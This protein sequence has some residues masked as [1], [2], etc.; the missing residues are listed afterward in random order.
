MLRLSLII[1]FLLIITSSCNPKTSNEENQNTWDVQNTKIVDSYDKINKF[2]IN[3]AQD[4]LF[5]FIK[6]FNNRKKNG[7][8]FY[9][10]SK[11]SDEANIENMWSIVYAV[12]YDT[13]LTILDNVPLKLI[14]FKINDTIKVTRGNVEDWAIYKGDSVL[15]GDFI[16]RHTK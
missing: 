14:N 7:F 12:R 2:A 11:F 16:R 8:E 4:S 9:I 15:Y 13:L 3:E 5:F 1:P 6:L 10:K